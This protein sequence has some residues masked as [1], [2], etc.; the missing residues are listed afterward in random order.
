LIQLKE[1]LWGYRQHLRAMISIPGCINRLRATLLALALVAL[2]AVPARAAD[3][4]AEIRAKLEDPA[5]LV[6]AGQELDRASLWFGYRERGFQPVWIGQPE[7]AKALATAFADAAADGIEPESLRAGLLAAALADPAR[8]AVERELLLS[9]RFLAYARALAQGQVDPATLEQDWALRRPGFD[10]GA[11]L[12][13]LAQSHDLAGIASSLRP[14]AD[15]YAR[16]RTALARYRGIAQAG[17][18][19]TLDGGKIEPGEK[20]P[21]VHALRARLAAEGDLPT[22]LAEGDDFDAPTKEAVKRFQSRHG[23]DADGR[24]GVATLAAL[25]V[26]AVDRVAQIR[27]TLERW[28]EMPRDWPATRIVVNAAAATLAFY[29]GG[30]PE[31]VSRVI[32]G[33]PMHPTPVLAA[34]AEFVLFNPP[35]KVPTSIVR[36]EIMPKVRRD[37]NYLARNHYVELGGGRLQ[38]EPGPW[39]A[40]GRIKLE[41]PNPFDVYLHDTPSRALFARSKRML[42]HGCIRVAAIKPLA[43]ALL[44]EGWTMAAIEEAIAAGTT[45]RVDLRE[46]VP[47]YILYLT[48]FVDADGTVQFRDDAYGR[49]GRLIEAL[50]SIVRTGAAASIAGEKLEA[51]CPA[52]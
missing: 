36:K 7:L 30:T 9:D 19:R 8:S 48:A 2:G 17:G 45:R 14:S 40:L 22:A 20:G 35:W 32:V 49:D 33:A 44:G 41:L 26:S 28:R 3:L 15:D 10:A 50:S 37:P 38:Q 18:W 43:L 12:G 31:I 6:V 16:L 34:R 27:A 23:L 47:V 51:G 13:R 1:H 29:R 11:V 46:S 25:D 42:S 52:G 39:N 24:V 5:P 4:P 21:R